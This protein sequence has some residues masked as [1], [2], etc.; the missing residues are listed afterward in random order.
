MDK[1]PVKV[2]SNNE[3][4]RTL[5]ETEASIKRFFSERGDDKLN[6]D[7][8][9]EAKSKADEINAEYGDI[10]FVAE[11]RGAFAVKFKNSHLGGAFEEYKDGEGEKSGNS[12]LKEAA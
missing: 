1:P 12:S 4:L 7:T 10:S 3:E 5:N 2:N 9:E 8:A 11:D 6:F